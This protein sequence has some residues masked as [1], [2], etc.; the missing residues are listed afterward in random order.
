MN[1][2]RSSSALLMSE[3]YSNALDNGLCTIVKYI[4]VEFRLLGR[5]L[6]NANSI[7]W[8]KD[9]SEC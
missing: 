6:V 7:Y 3:R 2:G 8:K 9:F 4:S 5:N 1:Q